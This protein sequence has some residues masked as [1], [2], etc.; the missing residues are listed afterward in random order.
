MRVIFV[1]VATF[2]RGL[3]VVIRDDGVTY[4]L[5]DGPV[6]G[7]LP[8]DLVHFSVEDELG[9]AD[10]IWGAIAGGVVFTSMTHVSGRRPPHS[11]ERS[12]T[13]MRAHREGLQRA[14]LIGGFVDRAASGAA[15]IGSMPEYFATLTNAGFDRDDVLRAVDRV[16]AEARRWAGSPVGA[17][18]TYDWPA[19]RCVRMTPARRNH[20]VGRDHRTAADRRSRA[21][22]ATRS[23]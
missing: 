23:R 17:E 13:L 9:I 10:G 8:H 1:R 2:A 18:L 21:G 7:R 19:H 15:H 4:H 3:S 6:T 5:A 12:T 16:R 11:A 14:E 20:R 22:R